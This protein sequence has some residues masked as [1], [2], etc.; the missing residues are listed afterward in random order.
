[1]KEDNVNK[2]NYFKIVW[3]VGLISLL[4]YILIIVI[5]YKVYYEY[6]I[7]YIY[8]YNCNDSLCYSNN[9]NSAGDNTIYSKYHYQDKIPNIKTL[10]NNY[11]LIDNNILYN[12][13]T[14]EVVTNLYET[15][16]VVGDSIIV[17]LNKKYGVIDKDGNILID[18]L[19]KEI[20]SNDGEYFNVKESMNDLPKLINRQNETILESVDYIFE[21][22]GVIVFV[23]DMILSIQDLEGNNLIGKTIGIYD[24][25]KLVSTS[26][27]NNILYIKIYK[28]DKYYRYSYN[29]ETKELITNA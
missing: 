4:C 7:G 27:D 10:N 29:I 2:I 6:T 12:Y 20:T 1:M 13:I 26:I 22:N 28:D 5:R 17:S 3:I 18:L 25:K 11:A 15:Y 24:K 8:F 23:K 14:G 21:Y 16:K 19:Y 9:R